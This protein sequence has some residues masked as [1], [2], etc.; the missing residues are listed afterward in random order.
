MLITETTPETWRSLQTEVAQILEECGFQVELERNVKLV[1]GAVK[2]DVFAEETYAGRRSAVIC[3]CKYWR[4]RVPQS[5]IHGFRTVM[6]DSG[7][8]FGYII[9]SAGFQSG[10]HSAAEFTN[11]QLCDWHEFQAEFLPTWIERHFLP[12]LADRFRPLS[13]LH[14]RTHRPMSSRHPMSHEQWT[15]FLHLANRWTPFVEVMEELT[16]YRASA[17]PQLPLREN[18]AELR[19]S[20]KHDPESRNFGRRLPAG[21]IDA[22]GYRQVMEIAL[23][24]QA[25]LFAEIRPTVGI[26]LPE[27]RRAGWQDIEEDEAVTSDRRPVQDH[28]PDFSRTG[29]PNRSNRLSRRRRP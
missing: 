20:K 24:H 28:A 9:S 16:P 1:R 6:A 11:V 17:V 12:T 21:L 23:E 2:V 5:V 19:F 15:A 8:N 14:G 29:L 7:A 22:A 13:Q 3:E 10:A 27:L 18:W 26:L 4:K 25:N